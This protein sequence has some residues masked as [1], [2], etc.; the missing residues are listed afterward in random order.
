MS[1]QKYINF[2]KKIMILLTLFRSKIIIFQSTFIFTFFIFMSFTST[3]LH[4]NSIQSS[5]DEDEFIRPNF[6]II[7]CDDLGYGD[8]ESFGAQH[9]RTPNFNSLAKEGM[10]FTDFYSTS[11]YCTPSRSSLITGSYP[12]RVDLHENAYPPGKTEMRQVLFAVAHKGINPKE[13]TIAEVLKD[14]GYKTAM[15]GKWHLGDQPE[16]LP[17]RHGFDSYLGIPYSND[18]GEQQFEGNPPLPLL[19]NETVIEAPV[20]QH[21]ITQ[22]YTVAALEFIEKNQDNPFFL[23]LAHTMPH[24]PIFSS[25]NFEGKSANGD[26]GDAIE[27]IDWS[28]GQILKTLDSLSLNEKTILIFTSD[29]GADRNFGGTNSPL[30]GHK[31]STMEGGMRVPMLIK[32][33]GMIPAGSVCRELATT[34]DLLP[35]FAHFAGAKL[36]EVKI[37]GKNIA[38]LL[39]QKGNTKSPY[40][41]FYYYQVDQLQ[42]VR[43]GDW[44]LHLPLEER[45]I[46]GVNNQIEKAEAKLYNLKTDIRESKNLASE[47]PDVVQLILKHADQAREDLGDRGKIGQNQRFASIVQSPKPLLKEVDN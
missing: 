17:T 1:Y 34:M 23:Y 40:E 38:D 44:K 42:A 3:Y 36:P 46:N 7:F 25:E 33:E 11:G 14:K 13:I 29:N 43:M 4:G 2:N 32:W 27:E 26:Y 6:I 45:R 41:A 9:H 19:K 8:L 12:R 24:N 18:M 28:L 30:S 21:T 39:F 20:D 47:Y 37:D 35:T 15:V 10:K 31:G 22:K 16:F 5:N